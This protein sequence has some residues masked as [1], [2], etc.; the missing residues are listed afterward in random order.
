MSEADASPAAA[1][2]RSG[3]RDLT[4]GPVLRTLVMFSL[5]TQGSNQLQSLNGT[6][7]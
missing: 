2:Q 4:S 1:P 7:N 6:V 3:M 5:P